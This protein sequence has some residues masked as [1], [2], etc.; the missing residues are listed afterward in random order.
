MRSKFLLWFLLLIAGFLT[1]FILQYARLQSL[2]QELSAA[3]KQ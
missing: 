2:R 1:G 3:T